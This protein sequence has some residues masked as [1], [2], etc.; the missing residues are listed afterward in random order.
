MY[1]FGH[2]GMALF[3]GFMLSLPMVFVMIG[4]ILPDIID[5]PLFL[6]GLAPSGRYISHTLIFFVATSIAT[7]LITRNKFATL[8]LSFGMA[9]H[10]FGDVF[11]FVPWFYPFVNYDFKPY[12]ILGWDPIAITAEIV[13]FVLLVIIVK[14]GVKLD[15]IRNKLSLKFRK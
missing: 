5:K 10:F 8:A 2:I 12:A 4:S 11:H 1:F 6:L 9:T 13:G 3:L 7:Y 14:Y 15:A